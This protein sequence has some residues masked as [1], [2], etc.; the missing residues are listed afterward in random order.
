MC[1]VSEACLMGDESCHSQIAPAMR[2]YSKLRFVSVAVVLY[3]AVSSSICAQA[4]LDNRPVRPA[5]PR[6]VESHAVRQSMARGVQF[7]IETQRDD[8]AWGGPQWT[9]GVDSDP[10]PGAFHSFDV[11]VTAMCLESLLD[12]EPSGAVGLAALSTAAARFVGQS[13]AIVITG[14]N[15]N[16]GNCQLGVPNG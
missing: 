5:P 6:P 9:G 15:L 10:V 14:G 1:N 11:A 3:V 16:F 7:L 13:V 8:G 12:A 2:I 4:T